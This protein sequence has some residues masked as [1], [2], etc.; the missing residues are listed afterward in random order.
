L[1]ADLW[2][3]AKLDNFKKRF[4]LETAK[5]FSEQVKVKERRKLRAR[6]KGFEGVW[7]GLGMFGLVGWSV[8]IPTLV[9]IF[10]GIW[11]DV[12]WPS[13]YSWTLMLLVAGLGCGCANAWFWVQRERKII[14][15]DRDHEES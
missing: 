15:E 5:D 14:S 13:K 4:R 3:S 6:R 8:A 10:L 11:I 1:F 2:S 9:G 7:F 12:T